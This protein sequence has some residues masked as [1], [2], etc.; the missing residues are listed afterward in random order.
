MRRYGILLFTACILAAAGSLLIS[1]GAMAYGKHSPAAPA[2]S[3]STADR[4]V[5]GAAF[6]PSKKDHDNGVGNNCDPGW[7][8]GNQ[9]RFPNQAGDSTGCRSKASTAAVSAATAAETAG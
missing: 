2:A 8:R 1:T 5:L 3:Q 4:D 6:D 7:G 9:A